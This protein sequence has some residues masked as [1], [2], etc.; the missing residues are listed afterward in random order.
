MALSVA[1]ILIS[2]CIHIISKTWRKMFTA[3]FQP[4]KKSWIIKE[5]T[6]VFLYFGFFP[7]NKEVITEC[8]LYNMLRKMEEL[9]LISHIS[10]YN[11]KSDLSFISGKTNLLFEKKN[12]GID[13]CWLPGTHQAYLS[14]PLLNK[15]GWKK[16]D[17]SLWVPII[18][19]RSLINYCHGHNRLHLGKLT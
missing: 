17:K 18:T 2:C 19:G 14:L 6:F 7:N 13:L 3:F 11:S 4:W 9:D 12:G 16:Y 15:R 1:Q 10:P 8:L 5:G